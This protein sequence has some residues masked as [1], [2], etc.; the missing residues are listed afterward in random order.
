LK[1]WITLTVL[2]VVGV[3]GS[4]AWR[5]WET[6][7]VSKAAAETLEEARYLVQAVQKEQDLSDFREQ[8]DDAWNTYGRARDLFANE[9]MAESLENSKRA[10]ALL[11]SIRDALK[12]QG[13]VGEAHF[14]SVAGR[15]EFRRGEHGDWEEARSRVSLRDGYYVRTGEGGSAEIMFVDGTLYHVRPGTL[16]VVSRSRTVAGTP[17]GRGI[18][19]RYG[20]LDLSTSKASN[21][22]ST[23]G[24]EADVRQDSAATVTYEEDSQSGRI[25]AFEGTVQVSSGSGL[26][27]QLRALQEVAQRGDRLTEPRSIPR[28]PQILGPRDNVEVSIDPDRPL[29]LTW[30]PVTGASRYELQVSRSQHFVDNVVEATDRQEPRATLG[31]RG[32]GA[33]LWRVRAINSNGSP[34]DWSQPR[35]FRAAQ[36]TSGVEGDTE[37]P[38]LSVL[39]VQ[40]YGSI[41]IISGTTE[42]GA[43]VLVRGEPAQVG[44]DG[45]FTK[46]LQ[47]YD[48]GWTFLDVRAKDAYGNETVRP[49]RVYVDSL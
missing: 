35:K 32:E 36:G 41:F 15:V 13:S 37:P 29:V 16:F 17:G 44:A 23:P 39:P 47:V 34:G 26:S 7:A 25:A 38:E 9:Q 28:A 46:T 20:W 19:M 49:V 2:L 12:D 33:F 42:P 43:S 18:R 4:V 45:A 21:R 1:G 5:Y 30:Q 22:I 11:S 24:A 40:T 10:V 8:Y 6:H 3:A 27:R 14:I 48:E 31:V